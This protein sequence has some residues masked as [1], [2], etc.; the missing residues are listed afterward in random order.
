MSRGVCVHVCGQR[1]AKTCLSVAGH[2]G[3]HCVICHVAS[4]VVGSLAYQPSSLPAASIG[5]SQGS[6]T[7]IGRVQ[8]NEARGPCASDPR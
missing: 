6:P 7:L 5:N 8:P 2:S 4:S 1:E 3:S